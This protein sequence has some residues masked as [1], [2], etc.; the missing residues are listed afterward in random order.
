MFFIFCNQQSEKKLK[1]LKKFQHAIQLT[2]GNQFVSSKSNL[3]SAFFLTN[4]CLQ[5][6]EIKKAV[7][8]LKVTLLTS[9]KRYDDGVKFT[10]SLTDD[11]FT[12]PYKK[13]IITDNFRAL[14]I[15]NDTL[16]RNAIYHKMTNNLEKYI[17]DKTISN[18]EFEEAYLDL[19]HIKQNYESKEQI[20]TDIKG[21]IKTYPNK[22]SFFN[23]LK[24]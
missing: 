21:L 18:K 20:N 5:C 1:C 22:E 8:D 19:Y 17:K 24:M 13:I 4:E 16:S 6:D 10:D 15:C 23:Y 9:M 2:Y 11:D 12:Y 14:A 7:I 3:D